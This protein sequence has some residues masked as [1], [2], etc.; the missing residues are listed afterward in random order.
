[1]RPTSDSTSVPAG[2]GQAS[3]PK[4]TPARAVAPIPLR[5]VRR[6]KPGFAGPAGYSFGQQ[7]GFI[8]ALNNGS[9]LF[10]TQSSPFLGIILYI[11]GNG[12]SP[13]RSWEGFEGR[14]VR[15]CQRPRRTG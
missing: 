9:F 11:P 10:M 7:C 8:L 14:G 4:A 12:G 5:N 13:T 2:S 6:V 3:S 1:M 15:A